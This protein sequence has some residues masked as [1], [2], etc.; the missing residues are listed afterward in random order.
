MELKTDKFQLLIKYII[1]INIFKFI[2]LKLKVDISLDE[3]V[4]DMDILLLT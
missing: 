3:A 1:G 4:V 2:I